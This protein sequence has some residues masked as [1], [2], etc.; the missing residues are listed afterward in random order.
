M[1]HIFPYVT[2]GPCL[3][4]LAKD[5]SPKARKSEEVPAGFVLISATTPLLMGAAKGCEMTGHLT[6]S[7]PVDAPFSILPPYSLFA[8]PL[9][10]EVVTLHCAAG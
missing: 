8:A 10:D 9:G 2:P 4:M 3:S 7:H 1:T 5:T 6:K